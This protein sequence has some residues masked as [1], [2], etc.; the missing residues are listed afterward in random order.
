MTHFS[1]KQ[2]L[3][4]LPSL[5]PVYALF[6]RC[7]RADGYVVKNYWH[8]LGERSR[9]PNAIDFLCFVDDQLVGVVNVFFFSE[10]I[11]LVVFVDPAFRRQGIAKKLLRVTFSK[12]RQYVVPNYSYIV[13]MGC[14]ALIEKCRNEGGQYDHE[15]VEM[16]APAV[17]PALL[18][19]EISLRQAT[20]AD[21]PQLA[22]IHE[23]SFN[24]PD[25][26]QM[27]KRF[28]VTMLE[29][30]RKIWLAYHPDGKAIGKLHLRDDFNR[31]VLHDVGILP[32]FRQKHYGRALMLTWL[33]Q[34]A[35]QYDKPI[36]VEV[37]GDNTAALRFYERCGFTLTQQ[38][39]FWKFKFK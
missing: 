18:A 25:R 35:S 39:Q 33:R 15:E 12:L 36:A 27:E 22:I 23:H 4:H 26:E 28:A 9:D 10:S 5:E 13:P 19:P 31:I 11:E 14:P 20:L 1:F 17:M 21:I 29:S 16:I 8:I 34:F 30:Y 2:G 37:L 32:E 7:Q 38:Y 6:Y 24:Q 3:V